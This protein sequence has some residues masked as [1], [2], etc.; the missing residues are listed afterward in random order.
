MVVAAEGKV[1]PMVRFAPGLFGLALF[2]FWVW[3]VIDVISTDRILVRNMEKNLWL[4]LVILVPSV[5]AIAWLVAGR[6][7]NAGFAPG[8]TAIR[9]P[10]SARGEAPRGPEDDPDWR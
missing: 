10:P 5:G 1:E 3:A 9:R 8:S 2:A 4:L 7:V 6:P